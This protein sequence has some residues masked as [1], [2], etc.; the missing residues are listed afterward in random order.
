M[1]SRTSQTPRFPTVSPSV[2]LSDYEYG[3]EIASPLG[4][5]VAQLHSNVA[6]RVIRLPTNRSLGESAAAYTWEQDVT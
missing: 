4:D 5:N 3:E 6:A 2:L 1:N